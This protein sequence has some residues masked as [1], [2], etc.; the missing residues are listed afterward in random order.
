MPISFNSIP[1]TL[2][3]PFAFVEFDNTAASSGPSMLTYKSLLFGPMLAAGSATAL[4]PVQVTSDE[5]ADDLFGAGSVLARLIRAYRAVDPFTE[6][7][8]VG[9]ADAGVDATID[10][11]VTGPATAAGTVALYIAGQLVEVTVAADD[12]AVEIAAAIEAAINADSQLPVTAAVGASVGVDDHI[13]TLTTRNGGAQGNEI[14]VR[15][16]Y[17]SSDATPAGVAIQVGATSGATQAL[18]GGASGGP[19][20]GDVLAAIGD[21][22][23]QIWAHPYTDAA[24]LTAIE[25]ELSS[26]FGPLEM[27]DTVAVTGTVVD[28]S[29]FV[30][31]VESRNSPHSTIMGIPGCPAAPWEV[32]GAYAGSLA[33]YGSIDPARPFQTLP[34]SGILPPAIEDRMTL[35]ERNIVVTAGGSTASVDAGGVVRVETSVTTYT[36]NALGAT[37][38]SYRQVNTLLTLMYL[39]Y[40]FRNQW[41]LAYPRAKLADDTA[42]IAAGQV[43]VTPKIAKAFCV[44]IFRGWEELGLV[45]NIDQFKSDLIVERNLTNRN[46]LD[47]QLPPD[48]INQ[49][50]TIAAQ[51]QFRL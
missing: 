36:E 20:A 13:V 18:M 28:Y 8:A 50:V 35:S 14:D 41:A 15:L 42:R 45:E 10:L 34:L 24:N 44:T 17:Y 37:D 38:E 26:R 1:S 30:T 48:L 25:T 23:Y 7:W 47:F 43:I 22:W 39:R 16:N 27:I 5:Q 46:R 19:D 12:T 29:S 2:R 4:V 51:I 9:Q 40:D 3:I 49:L 6:L 32:A 33:Y 31:L 21:E 11:T